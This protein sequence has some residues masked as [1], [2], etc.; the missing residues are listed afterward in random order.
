MP[1]R[2][3]TPLDV[4]DL[5]LSNEFQLSLV[6]DSSHSWTDDLPVCRMSGIG[7]STN[8]IYR[9]N[10]IRREEHP[11][12][13]RSFRFIL[14]NTYFYGI[15]DGHD[16]SRSADFASQRMPAEVLLDQLKGKDL[17]EEIRDVLLQAFHTVEKGFFE[18]IDDLLADKASL[19]FQ[20][21][22]LSSYEAYQ[23]H[24]EVVERLRKTMTMVSSGTTAVVAL[25]KNNKLYIANVGDS[26]ALLCK[27][28]AQGVTRVIQLSVDHDICNE[29]ELLRLSHLGLDTE[30]ICRGSKLGNQDNTRCI[31]NY[32]VKGGYKE[33]DNLSAARGEPVIAEPDI[34]VGIPIDDSCMFLLL[35]SDGLYKSLE[36]ATG[37]N[38]ANLEIAEL[39]LQQFGIQSTLTGVAQAVVDQIVRIHHDTYMENN[40]QGA[41]QKRDDITLLVRNFNQLLLKAPQPSPNGLRSLNPFLQQEW[42]R[43]NNETITSS[44]ASQG[45]PKLFQENNT[46]QTLTLDEQQR[47]KPYVDFS[48]YYAEVDKARKRGDLPP[49]FDF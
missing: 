47:I 19:Q 36:E 23:K 28:D 12:E 20:L 42:P 1:T 27:K 48:D 43:D 37:T 40:R 25:I 11:F 13:D 14:D 35:M 15:F 46:G 34:C 24:P 5:D 21:Q 39:V 26:R 22:G 44:S 10:G 38:Q 33:F 6:S 3:E 16:G 45:P 18:T 30:K 8:Q 31:G 49:D 17:D 32:L 2:P 29:D 9:E 7:T 41:P 4:S